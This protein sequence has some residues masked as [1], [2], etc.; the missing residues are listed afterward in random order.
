MEYNLLIL[1]L[2][3]INPFKFHLFHAK[4][5]NSFK[6]RYL[7]LQI[8]NYKYLYLKKSKPVYQLE[9]CLDRLL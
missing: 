3:R 7:Q 8:E 4:S 2:Q 6:L 1:S 5:I 9:V